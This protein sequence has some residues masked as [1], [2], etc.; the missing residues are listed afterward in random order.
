MTLALPSALS[1]LDEPDYNGATIPPGPVAL[2]CAHGDCRTFALHLSSVDCY[3]ILEPDYDFHQSDLR[4]LETLLRD[5][6]RGD[7]GNWRGISFFP[8]RPEDENYTLDGVEKAEPAWHLAALLPTPAAQLVLAQS[9]RDGIDETTG[10]FRGW[11]G[12]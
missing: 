2:H 3:G 10:Q 12:Q 9:F 7:L 5:A 1:Y 11:G 8:G 4:W 6:S